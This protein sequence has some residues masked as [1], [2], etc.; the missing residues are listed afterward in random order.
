MLY[1]TDRWVCASYFI[2]TQTLEIVDLQRPKTKDTLK[3]LF[4][5]MLKQIGKYVIKTVTYVQQDEKSTDGGILILQYLYLTYYKNLPFNKQSPSEKELFRQRVLWLIFKSER[6]RQIKYPPLPP[7]TAFNEQELK[8]FKPTDP[9]LND[10]LTGFEVS[11]ED[12]EVLQKQ[13]KSSPSMM[14]FWLSYLY[15]F[16]IDRKP[17]MLPFFVVANGAVSQ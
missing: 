13:G 15:S 14:A 6:S 2:K 10:S 11:L 5:N 8:S 16:D 9:V 4:D 7:L 17:P 3:K 1:F 12:Y